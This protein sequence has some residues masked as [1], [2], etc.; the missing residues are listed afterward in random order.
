MTPQY[1]FQT[2]W[3]NKVQQFAKKQEVTDALLC[4]QK[5]RGP[6]PNLLQIRETFP[7]ECV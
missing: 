4:G 6:Q 7:R 1:F 3:T 2:Q 5:S